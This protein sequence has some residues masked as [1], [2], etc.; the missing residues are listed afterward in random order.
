MNVTAIDN[1]L[2][3]S[4]CKY[5]LNPKMLDCGR[6]A[7]C[8]KFVI[9][10]Y[11]FHMRTQGWVNVHLQ[12]LTKLKKLPCKNWLNPKMLVL[13]LD[14]RTAGRLSFVIHSYQFHTW[15]G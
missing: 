12:I 10:S 13:Y 9:H 3:K 8:L 14:G 15:R 6:T 7:G 2:K 1:F 11:R 5:W 4:P